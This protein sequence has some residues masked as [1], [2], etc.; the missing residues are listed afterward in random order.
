VRLLRDYERAT[1]RYFQRL[2]ELREKT[3]VSPKAEYDRLRQMVE[4]ARAESE[5][6]RDALGLHIAQHGC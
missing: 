6:A 5:S 3:P 2:H 4:Q 1:E